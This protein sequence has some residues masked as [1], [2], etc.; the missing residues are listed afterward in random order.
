MTKDVWRQAS[1]IS[2]I[3]YNAKCMI[4]SMATLLMEPQNIMSEC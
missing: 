1:I 4:W 2:Q 3:Y